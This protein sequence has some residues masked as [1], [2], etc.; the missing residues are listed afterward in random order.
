MSDFKVGDKV[1]AITVAS[2]ESLARDFHDTYERLAPS[3][4]YETRPETRRFDRES[5]NGRLMV[6]V[7]GEI[8]SRHFAPLCE[9]PKENHD[10][11][12]FPKKPCRQCGKTDRPQWD[13]VCND[14][15]CDIEVEP[16]DNF[17]KDAEVA[18]LAAA[19]KVMDA[20]RNLVAD[21]H[22]AEQAPDELKRAVEY[23]RT[24][25]LFTDMTN[26]L[27]ALDA[28]KEAKCF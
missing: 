7:C 10:C 26:A 25:V 16:K 12:D 11:T 28:A 27:S 1:C 2:A 20:A 24:H 18:R 5:S 4:G 22:L 9:Q 23:V 19:E 17:A 8:L 3:F 15:N 21:F 14:G 6:A 13:G